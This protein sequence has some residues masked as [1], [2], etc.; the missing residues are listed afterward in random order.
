MAAQT[1]Q[2]P[3]LAFQLFVYLEFDIS[4]YCPGKLLLPAASPGADE[5]FQGIMDADYT[6]S[7]YGPGLDH[8]WRL[9]FVSIQA[10]EAW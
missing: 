8:L 5:N 7:E 3:G 6:G 10:Q 2:V 1:D 9:A 4:G